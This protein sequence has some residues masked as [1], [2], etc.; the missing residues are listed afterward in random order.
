MESQCVSINISAPLNGK[1][2][3]ELSDSEHSQYPANHL[4]P[5]E[6]FFIYRATQVNKSALM[7]LHPGYNEISDSLHAYENKWVQANC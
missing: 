3:C 7:M 1:V 2:I 4:D 6:G 5:R